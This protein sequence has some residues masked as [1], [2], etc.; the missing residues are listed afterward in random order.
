MLIAAQGAMLMN[1]YEL[2]VVIHD[3]TANSSLA[4]SEQVNAKLYER[5]KPRITMIAKAFDKTTN[6][7]S[8]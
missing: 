3:T 4:V 7:R 5:T 8:Q 1:E 6:N 2:S